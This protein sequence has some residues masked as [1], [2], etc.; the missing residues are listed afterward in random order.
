[1]TE[2]Q[3]NMIDGLLQSMEDKMRC[4]SQY[5]HLLMEKRDS[6][7]QKLKTKNNLR[8][9]QWKDRSDPSQLPKHFGVDGAMIT[10]PAQG[11]SLSVVTSARVSSQNDT[12]SINGSIASIDVIP[13]IQVADVITRGIMTMMEMLLIDEG[14][15]MDEE[16]YALMDGG[17]ISVLIAINMFYEA[18]VYHAP[19]LLD[20][21]RHDAS[22]H[23]RILQLFE[24]RDIFSRVMSSDRI[25]GHLK[26]VSTQ[27]LVKQMQ[28]T[29]ML[30]LIDDQGL[31]NL[32]LEDGESIDLPYE[33]H[34][35][36]LHMNEAFVYRD[37]L[38]QVIQK[39]SHHGHP[40]NLHHIYAKTHPFHGV[41]KIEVNQGMLDRIGLEACF[42][43]WQILC[44]N[45]EIEAPMPLYIADTLTSKVVSTMP[46]IYT[47]RIHH[48]LGQHPWARP[49]RN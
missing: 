8:F 6:L 36:I 45:H 18:M 1:M 30:G 3:T 49:Y 37:S 40:W 9:D 13:H 41:Y 43:Q 42:R 4:L 29:D 20:Q 12:A 7:R 34:G 48:E 28:L 25:M 11:S 10:L 23:G 14:L 31:V 24:Q 5:N 38:N 15:S 46:K 17:R 16:F 2:L 47:D 35:A 22:G 27:N 44:D 33:T 39:W 32:L 26:L 21:W 19:G